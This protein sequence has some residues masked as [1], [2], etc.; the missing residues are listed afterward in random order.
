MSKKLNVKYF[1]QDTSSSWASENPKMSEGVIAYET[2]T[3][4]IKLFDGEHSFSELSYVGGEGSSGGAS[5]YS[6]LTG[7]PQINSV[8]LSGNKS[9]DDLGIQAKGE[10]A[11]KAQ[12]AKADTAVQPSAL[13]AYLTT[14]T[15]T[16]T[17]A[18]KSELAD[19]ADTSALDAYLTTANA[20]ST[21]L[22]KTDASS[23]YATKASLSGYATTSALAGKADKETTLDGYGI[24][25]AY[26]KTEADGKYATKASLSGYA[27]TSA[28]PTTTSD[29]TNDSG[30]ITASVNNLANYTLTSALATVAT[31]GSYNDL[32]NKPTI[33]TSYND[34]TDKP[35][36]PSAYVL[37]TASTTTLGG[38]KV[39]GTTVTISGGVISAPAA[40]IAT[41]STAGV[42]KPDD[43]TFEMEE[44]G[45][46]VNKTAGSNCYIYGVNGIGTQ[47][48]TDS[49]DT[50]TTIPVGRLRNYDYEN[51]DRLKVGDM[52]IDLKGNIAKVDRVNTA[53]LPAG[54]G[55]Y[56][57]DESSILI[58]LQVREDETLTTTSK[59][60][61]GAINE[62][63]SRITS[64]EA[65]VAALESP[66]T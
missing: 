7:K 36:I 26:T 3:N 37:P 41:T 20:T 51:G 31:S 12:G 32:S 64:L 24:T 27:Q 21:Y 47:D 43:R 15:A 1:I 49:A 17:Y 56:G 59:E 34:L 52:L 40:S 9:L 28:I 11:T 14:E 4:K 58:K 66:T 54:S 44:D 22:S 63:V 48:I 8:E 35:S 18:T 6:S 38:V 55:P 57:V 10:Y 23:T 30:F 13:S 39:D 65:R 61:V 5:D 19:K 33:I 25:D 2:D 42:V 53:V 16:S 29:L 46:L 60:I 50:T 45:T 62:L